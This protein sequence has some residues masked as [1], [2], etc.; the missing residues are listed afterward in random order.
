M[1]ANEYTD[2]LAI[3]DTG[4]QSNGDYLVEIDLQAIHLSRAGLVHGGMVFTMLDAA[5]GRAVIARL[6]PGFTSPTIEMKINF[7]RP[8]AAGKLIA[9]GRIVNS[10]KQLSY[11]EGEVN[12]E[13]GKLVA[14]ATGTFF[15]KPIQTEA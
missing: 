15:V 4:L 9:R 1:S 13:E 10:S 8:A 5:M 7:F 6:Q 11:A 14:R 2:H 3:C 12:N